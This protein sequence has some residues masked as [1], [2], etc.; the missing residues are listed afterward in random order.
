MC[1]YANIFHP[2]ACNSGTSSGSHYT[3]KLVLF[4]EID[5]EGNEWKVNPSSIHMKV[6][7][8]FFNLP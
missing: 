7:H 5:E 8:Y 3:V 2:F 6:R 4:K 1:S